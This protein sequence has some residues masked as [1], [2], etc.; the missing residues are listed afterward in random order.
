M[1]CDVSSHRKYVLAVWGSVACFGGLQAMDTRDCA[2]WRWRRRMRLRD[3]RYVQ[4][5]ERGFCA[6]VSLSVRV[7]KA[8]ESTGEVAFTSRRLP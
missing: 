6:S 2:L 3:F 8:R 5:R 1:G 4:H 7:L